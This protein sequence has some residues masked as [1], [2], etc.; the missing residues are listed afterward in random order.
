MRDV[1]AGILAAEACPRKPR[2]VT[3]V[4]VLAWFRR[5]RRY[6]AL[7]Q[8]LFPGD[9]GGDA[10]STLFGISNWHEEGLGG[11]LWTHVYADRSERW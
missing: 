1:G 6:D 2:F 5:T 8:R 9:P 4:D 7:V 10:F 11:S 3:S